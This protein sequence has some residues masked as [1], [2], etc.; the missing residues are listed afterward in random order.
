MISYVGRGARTDGVR[1]GV[2][3]EDMEE[4]GDGEKNGK[5][6]REEV[7]IEAGVRRRI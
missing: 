2:K 6:R 3:V 1:A 5:R 4:G 7:G